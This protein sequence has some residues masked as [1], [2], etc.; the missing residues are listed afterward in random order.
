MQPEAALNRTK[1]T[2]RRP[3]NEQRDLAQNQTVEWFVR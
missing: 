1:L 2:P 3:A